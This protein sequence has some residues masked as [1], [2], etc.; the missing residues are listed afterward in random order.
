LVFDGGT[1]EEI[2]AVVGVE[3]I[4]GAVEDAAEL[5]YISVTL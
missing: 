1:V 4:A 3:G 5:D 2:E